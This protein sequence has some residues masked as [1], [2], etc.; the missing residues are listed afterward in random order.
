MND[1]KMDKMEIDHTKNAFIFSG[2]ITYLQ[3]V[4]D[5]AMGK[6]FPSDIGCEKHPLIKYMLDLKKRDNG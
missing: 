5:C 3:G 4:I 2:Q 1:K 6:D